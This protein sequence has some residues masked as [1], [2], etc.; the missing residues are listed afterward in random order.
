[1]ADD[2]NQ[3]SI[4]DNIDA[5]EQDNDAES[6]LKETIIDIGNAA[7]NTSKQF[8]DFTEKEENIVTFS[9]SAI[10]VGQS[11]LL[12]FSNIGKDIIPQATQA[13]ANLSQKMESEPKAA[14]SILGNALNDPIQGLK[15]LT[16]A[17]ITFSNSQKQVISQ[18][19]STGSIAGAQKL[20]LQELNEKL[21]IEASNAA[22]A[23]EGNMK[24]VKSTM[25]SL[26]TSISSSVL[27]TFKSLKDS[28]KD[29]SDTVKK[30]SDV[31]SKVKS[32]ITNIT[33]GVTKVINVIKKLNSI[34]DVITS[35]SGKIISLFTGLGGKMTSGLT[36]LINIGLK[37]IAPAAMIGVVLVG[38]GLLQTQMGKQ[39]DLIAKQL[40]A[41]GPALIK[42]FSDMLVAQIPQLIAAGTTLFNTLLNVLIAN[43]PSLLKAATAIIT[44]LVNGVSTNLPRLIPEMI[45]LIETILNAIVQNLPTIIMA[46]LKLILALV[47]GISSNISQIVNSIVQVIV[48]IINVMYQNLPQIIQVGVQILVAIVGGLLKAIPQ[49]IAAIPQI[50]DAIKN[51]IK[52][53]NWLDLGGNIIQGLI[54]GI[55]AGVEDLR[56]T[57]KKLAKGAVNIVKS[58]LGIH[59]PSRVFADEIGKFIPAGV[60]VG[61]EE[62]SDTVISSLGNMSR[63][64]VDSMQN[65]K[66]SILGAARE[67]SNMNFQ[68][69][70]MPRAAEKLNGKDSI[71]QSA[72]SGGI[73][74]NITINSNTPLSPS[75][76]IR[77]Q[78]QASRELAL[79][80]GF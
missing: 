41:K 16:N 28:F 55:E 45:Q 22:K 66:S 5:V 43:A 24:Q 68:M 46:G 8:E 50:I 54:K 37:A 67:L 44:S 57:M 58:F 17:G 18:M 6:I 27:P 69:G 9:K 36:K 56:N 74:Q 35:I 40:I 63:K 13:L 59:S 32:V 19:V 10:E 53:V 29:V 76:I 12:T 26:K 70:L 73:T 15:L 49:L 48:T 77:K 80:W 42:Q 39:I 2:T 31:Y 47:Q 20:I 52:S 14:A 30:F 3:K 33:S 4:N 62:N 23:F 51:G 64:M 38:L 71:N 25:E 72:R 1:M 75:E 65:N 61:I 7:E 34:I 60:G 78:K 79:Q 21:G 11:M